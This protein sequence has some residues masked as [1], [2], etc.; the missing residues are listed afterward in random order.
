MIRILV[1]PRKIVEGQPENRYDEDPEV[2]PGPQVKRNLISEDIRFHLDLAVY[3]KGSPA[4]CSREEVEQDIQYYQ[5]PFIHKEV[6]IA[7]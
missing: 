3:I 1:F 5:G 7:T 2:E 4:E 6:E